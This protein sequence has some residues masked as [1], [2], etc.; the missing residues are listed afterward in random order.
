MIPLR[1]LSEGCPRFRWARSVLGLF[2]AWLGVWNCAAAPESVV[3][4]LKNGDRITGELVS[5]NGQ[6]V[7]IRS[8]V[9]GKVTIPR[10]NLDH[11]DPLV[12]PTAA[13]TATPTN[14]APK[15]ATPS[16]PAPSPAAIATADTNAPVVGHLLPSWVSGIW[17]NWHGNVQ[18][19]LN[20]GVGTTDRATMYVNGSASKKWGRTSTLFTYNSAYGEANG[21][22]NANQMAGTGRADVDISPNRRTF[23]YA[24]G[25]AGYDV[26]RK[27][28]LEYLG[29]GGLGFKFIDRPKRVLAGELGIQYQDFNYSTSDDQSTVAV[30]F[31]ESFTT[32]IEKLSITQRLGFTPGIGDLSNYQINF[33]LTLSYPLFKPLTL[34]LNVIDQY[35]S[36]PAAG[37]QNNDIQV[38]TTIGV[39][40]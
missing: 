27:I 29:G 24:S 39:T 4:F 22:Q 30:R 5:T 15:A 25:A 32:S 28:D 2:L 12:R 13:N 26:I 6:R 37:V 9:V 38:Q 8:P 18:A 21:V 11:M 23:A 31:G 16:P 19:G 3:L 7:I 36:R 1:R 20:L 33:F 34:N 35:L 10:E 40:F 14:A 17:T